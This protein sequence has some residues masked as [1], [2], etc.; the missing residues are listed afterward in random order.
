MIEGLAGLI[1]A[2]RSAE[3]IFAGRVR[4]T[5]GSPEPRVYTMP[6]LSRRANRSWLEDLNAATAGALDD[7]GTLTDAT[8]ILLLLSAKSDA[9]LDAL[10]S[11]DQTHALPSREAIDASA[12]DIQIVAAIVEVWLAANPPFVAVALGLAEATP[13]PASSPTAPAP[14]AGGRASSRTS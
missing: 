5:L 12:S 1:P 13:S 11:Y 8:E 2:K 14:T 10:V 4:V 6:V 7:L 9:F 3:D